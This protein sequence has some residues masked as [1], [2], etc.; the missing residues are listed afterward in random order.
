L[1]DIFGTLQLYK[2]GYNCAL[3]S[4]GIFNFSK[5]IVYNGGTVAGIFVLLIFWM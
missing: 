5:I 2:S 3:A 1:T 4:P